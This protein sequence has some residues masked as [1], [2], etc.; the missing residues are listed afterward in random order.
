MDICSFWRN[1]AFAHWSTPYAL[2][3][4]WGLCTWYPTLTHILSHSDSIEVSAAMLL[5][6]WKPFIMNKS[7]GERSSSFFSLN[8]DCI[9]NRSD[10]SSESHK[11]NS[12]W[13]QGKVFFFCLIRC[14]SF[15]YAADTDWKSGY[16]YTV[17]HSRAHFWQSQKALGLRLL[18]QHDRLM[19]VSG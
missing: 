4:L 6:T 1:A 12:L 2:C 7:G 16:N 19:D 8:S 15:L 13:I 5:W 9:I 11:H 3:V 18:D 10:W 17:K 14:S